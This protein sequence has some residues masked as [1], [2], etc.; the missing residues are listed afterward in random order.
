MGAGN[1]Y[2]EIILT[3]KVCVRLRPLLDWERAENQT[4][5]LLELDGPGASVT[6]QAL[7]NAE[8]DVALDGNATT[9]G[10]G[11]FGQLGGAYCAGKF[12]AFAD[13]EFVPN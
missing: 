12:A 11:G 2:S 4:S 1:I 5:S 7:K 3:C 6:L 9:A 10:P 13:P 8:D